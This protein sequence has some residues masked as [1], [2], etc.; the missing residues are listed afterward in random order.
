MKKLKIIVGSKNPV[1]IKCVENVFSKYFDNVKVIGKKVKSGVSHQPIT[2][3]ET[4][5]GAISRANQVF[6]K[7]RL[8]FAVGI[9]GGIGYIEKYPLRICLGLH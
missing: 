5:L 1:K 2:E 9:E 7:Y 6:K 4:I 8:H 3:K